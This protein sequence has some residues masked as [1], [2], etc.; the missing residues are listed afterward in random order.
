MIVLL[1]SPQVEALGITVVSGD[2]WRDEEVAH[3]LRMLEIIGRTEVPV[4][5]GAIFP[6]IN[7]LETIERWE[8]LYG[9]VAYKGAWNRK[10][11]GDGVRGTFH[12]PYEVPDIVEGNPTTKP[13]DEDAAHFIIRMVHKYPHEVTIYAGGPLTNLAQALSIDPKV[14]DLAQELVIM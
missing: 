2:Q 9:K 8:S 13:A 14:S 11:T 10:A 5:P 3:T 12:G 6:L 4:F 7:R 1:Q